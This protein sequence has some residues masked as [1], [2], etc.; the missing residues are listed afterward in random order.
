MHICVLR[1]IPDDEFLRQRWNEL[2]RKMEQPEIFYTYEWAVSVQRSYG[3]ILRPLLLLGYDDARLI[4]V[5]AL[6]EK[7]QGHVHFLAESTAD[8]CDFLSSP[9]MR[10]SWCGAVFGELRKLHL[11]PLRLANLPAD[12]VT[13]SVVAAI[14]KKHRYHSFVRPAY[15]CARIAVGDD[16]QRASLRRRTTGK[17]SFLRDLRRLDE[18]GQAVF[19]TNVRNDD[20]SQVVATFCRAH[21]G[22]FLGNGRLSNMVKPERRNFLQE[23][24]S[25]LAKQGWL[26]MD[27]LLVGDRCVAWNYGFQFAGSWFWYQPTF[28]TAYERFSPGLC[29]LR[30]II[31]TACDNPEIK[32]VDLGLGAEG[33]KEKFANA[34]RQTLHVS[35][36]SSRISHARLVLR[37]RVVEAIKGRPKLETHVRS[38]LSRV[39]RLQCHL[40]GRGLRSSLRVL[41]ARARH[42][43]MGQQEVHFFQW[44]GDPIETEREG[45]AI[46]EL[47]Q[48]LLA[49][50]AMEYNADQ[51]TLDY[52][53]R[54]A[55]RLQTA[56]QRGFAL[57]TSS[58]T[59]LHFS[60]VTEF[61]N[62]EVHELR[63]H[64]R[65]PSH[66]AV[67]IFDS[68]SPESVRGHNHFATA[69]AAI[70]RRLLS[71]GEVPWIFAA[72][73]NHASLKGIVKAGF[74]YQFTMSRRRALG[75]QSRVE[76]IHKPLAPL[77][78]MN[79]GFQ[80]AP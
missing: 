58:G 23:L 15:R 1:E 14:A 56:R 47:D 77:T 12:S 48:D 59:P 19:S 61:E 31:E 42:Y 40:R 38:A 60:W 39:T 55:Q 21:V 25:Q 79:S 76:M 65:A 33:Y 54:A 67:L 34:G 74:S 36:S 71:S 7:P 73:E 51:S 46:H 16:E 41:G 24:A 57:V 2:V 28:D 3:S 49:T 66:K 45:L 78:I 10:Q 29:L 64:L 50:A 52:L 22:R 69:I 75:L 13:A 9:T 80:V 32:V 17:Q 4:G 26:S 27:R 68:W 8:Y 62:F 11:G 72:A 30:K 18:K 44:C 43:F 35:L 63:E 5:A 6:A 70:A 20:L 53:L 37:H